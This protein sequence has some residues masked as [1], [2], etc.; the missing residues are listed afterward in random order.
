MRAFMC[1]IMGLCLALTCACAEAQ[2]PVYDSF[3]TEPLHERWTVDSAG[4]NTASVDLK[5][6]ALML[7]GL[8]NQFNH[9]ETPMPDGADRVQ[10]DIC[11]ISDITASWSPGLILYWD[12][13]NWVRLMVSLMY[14]LRVLSS[15]DQEHEVTPGGLKI[16]AGDWYRCAMQMEA[17]TVRVMCAPVGEPLREVA[18][19]PRPESWTGQPTIIIG[20]GYMHRG[21][22]NPDFDNNY[23]KAAKRTRV[24][25]DDVIIGDP[26]GLADQIAASMTQLSSRSPSGPASP[27][28]TLR[29][30]SGSR[31]T[32]ISV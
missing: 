22:G 18:V 2:L 4:D 26:T 7:A 3:D 13:G 20:K 31:R 5:R 29:T 10:V 17:D 32:S 14:D 15:V 28:P 19:L 9:V 1:S 11:N 23:H 8:D 21:T 16:R 12:D 25:C 6:Q 30:P 27:I 24:A